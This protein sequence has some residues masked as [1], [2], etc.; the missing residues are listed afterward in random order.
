MS[1]LLMCSVSGLQNDHRDLMKEIEEKLYEIHECARKNQSNSSREDNSSLNRDSRADLVGF[2]VV[3][4]VAVGGPAEQAVS[5]SE[6][7]NIH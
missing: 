7:E 3:N 4:Q 1:D 2:L 6:R 5:V